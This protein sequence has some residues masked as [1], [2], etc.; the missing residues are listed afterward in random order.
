MKKILKTIMLLMI[1]VFSLQLCVQADM[2]APMIE[3][4]KATVINPDGIDCY[5]YEGDLVISLEYGD[6]IEISYEYTD[7]EDGELYASFELDTDTYSTATVNLKD[8]APV[9]EVHVAKKLDFD[10]PKN[11]VVVSEEG[12]ELYNGPSLAYEKMNVNLPRG[13]EIVVYSEKESYDN[14]WY[15]TTYEGNSG[16]VCELDTLGTY[17]EDEEIFIEEVGFYEFKTGAEVPKK[18]GT[19]P[20]KTIIKNCIQLDPWRQSYYVKYNGQWGIV[21]DREG[22]FEREEILIYTSDEDLKI[23][24]KY[25]NSYMI[26]NPEDFDLDDIKVIGTIPKNTKIAHKYDYYTG[27]TAYVSY[28][29][30]QGWIITPYFENIEYVKTTDL[31]LPSF[32]EFT[33]I[34]VPK[35]TSE[36]DIAGDEEN[37]VEE[38]EEDKLITIQVT[39]EQIV[40]FAV[41]IAV[42]VS[43]TCVVTI[44]LINKTSKKDNK[45]EEINSEV[46]EENK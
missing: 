23:Y 4:Y 7:A 29:G 15:Y 28:K 6:E 25:V 2:S 32:E 31:E 35:L 3:P 39:P 33:V 37:T 1:L 27:D 17:I 40:L 13:T 46:K 24:D 12:A 45:K 8:I 44:V 9:D 11:K 16:W 14:P 30:I 18:I 42:V 34:E 38:N 5:N 20:A 43:L 36:E 19:I 21:S 22:L 41:V 10:K 26:E